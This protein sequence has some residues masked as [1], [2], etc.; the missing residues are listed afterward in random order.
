MMLTQRMKSLVH[1]LIP[2]ALTLSP[3]WLTL[4]GGLRV[5]I[6]SKL[7]LELLVELFATQPYRGGLNWSAHHLGE[8]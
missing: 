3:A 7:I 1:R 4:E 2:D 6:D 5:R 8:S